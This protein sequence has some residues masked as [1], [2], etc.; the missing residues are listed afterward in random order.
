MQSLFWEANRFAASQEIPRILWNPK[1]HYRI[2]K[3]PPP[4]SILNR[5]NLVHAPHPTSWRPILIL[6]SHLRLG[7]LGDLFPTDFPTK[8][9]YAYLLPPIR[10]TFPAHLSILDLITQITF[11]MKC[12]SLCSSLYSYFHSSF[13]SSLLGPNIPLSTLFL[14]TLSKCSRFTNYNPHEM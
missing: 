2:H 1:V 5:N 10:A 3:C 7:L 8:T 4:V 14:N 12:R 13:T 6:S 11:R 9:L